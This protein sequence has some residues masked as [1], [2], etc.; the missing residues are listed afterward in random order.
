MSVTAPTR[1]ERGGA[2]RPIRRASPRHPY[3]TN[4]TTSPATSARSQGDMRRKLARGRAGDSIAG[5]VSAPRAYDAVDRRCRATRA[6]RSRICANA[7]RSAI[8]NR[9]AARLLERDAR[10]ALLAVHQHLE[11]EVR[12]RGETGAA[13]V[14]DRLAD[15]DVRSDVNARARSGSDGRIA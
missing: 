9:I 4:A 2:A 7:A 6:V 3:C 8:R 12:P 10:I 13:D 15:R 1:S 14:R 5:R 11:V